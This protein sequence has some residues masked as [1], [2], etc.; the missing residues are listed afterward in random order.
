MGQCAS[1]KMLLE[2]EKKNKTKHEAQTQSSRRQVCGT[3]RHT[4]PP[5]PTTA[6]PLLVPRPGEEGAAGS[7]GVGWWGAHR[8]GRARCLWGEWA[9]APQQ[10]F[11]GWLANVNNAWAMHIWRLDRMGCH[12]NVHWA[13]VGRCLFRR[14]RDAFL[15][16]S[17]A[18]FERWVLF[19]V[20]NPSDRFRAKGLRIVKLR[21]WAQN[22]QDGH[23]RWL[24]NRCVESCNLRS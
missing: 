10:W 7:R 1:L 18:N 15:L 14:A 17:H 9:S 16:L 5:H 4:V 23:T 20:K 13:R 2:W 8:T 12:L 3:H 22:L 11:Q 21:H 24:A 6:A 19:F